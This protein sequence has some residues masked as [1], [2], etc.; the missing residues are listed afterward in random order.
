MASASL[1]PSSCSS[2]LLLP[3][4]AL[5]GSAL[6][7]LTNPQRFPARWTQTYAH[8]GHSGACHSPRDV[9]AFDVPSRASAGLN[10][11]ASGVHL[12]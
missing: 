12:S 4:P 11:T 7:L 8:A 2:M 5:A 1:P 9:A 6:H 3:G 10:S